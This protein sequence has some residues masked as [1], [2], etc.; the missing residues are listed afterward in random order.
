MRGAAHGAGIVCV[1][2]VTVAPVF[3][4]IDSSVNRRSS[5]QTRA[6]VPNAFI[7]K[8]RRNAEVRAKR[9]L[10]KGVLR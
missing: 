6:R 3:P 10:S 1:S 5:T 2:S 4:G 7:Q 9:V 8:A